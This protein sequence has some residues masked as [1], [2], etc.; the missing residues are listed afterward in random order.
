ME[1]MNFKRRV[2][3]RTAQGKYVVKTEKGVSYNP[4]AKFYKNTV[5][6]PIRPKFERVT[7]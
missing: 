2:I 1:S 7:S 3:Y 4:K 5:P 6:S